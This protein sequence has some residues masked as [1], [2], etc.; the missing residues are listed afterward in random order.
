MRYPNTVYNTID[1][2]NSIYDLATY[3]L[4]GNA[5]N[6]TAWVACY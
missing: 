2:N 3:R 5:L 6:E 4:P 1:N